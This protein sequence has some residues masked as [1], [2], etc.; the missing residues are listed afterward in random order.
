M[1]SKE[2][3]RLRAEDREVL[4]AR[5]RSRN[6]RADDARRAR[7]ILMLSDGATYDDV[8][9]AVGCGR[10]YIA[11]W[12][13]R[14]LEQGVAGMYARH[15]GR[16]A[17]AM[18]PR[19]EA[20]ILAR[21]QRKPKD[22]STH[23]S[24]RKLADEVGVSHMLVQRVWARA[25]I[26]PHRIKR[27]MA[28]NDPDFESKAADV[29]GLYLNPPQHAAV[30]SLDEKTQVQALDRLVPVLPLSPGRLER[31]GFEY[32]RHGTLSLY[33]ALNTRTGRVLGAPVEKH[34][35]AALVAFLESLLASVPRRQEVHVIL[36]N[37]SAH[38]SRLVQRFLVDHP[39]LHF[40]FTPTYSSWLN[41]I[42]IW[43]SKIERD[44]IARG[45]FTS[46]K[47]LARKLMRYIKRYNQHPK[48][49]KWKYSDPARRIRI[50]GSASA[51]TGN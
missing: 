44:V 46:V 10:A 25:G 28:S 13:G 22:G 49:I 21:T 40:H 11:R 20:R 33:A 8:Q 32:Y 12:R 26:K 1:R 36:D 45:V 29:I 51:V 6:G 17:T 37:L 4:E 14:F 2:P 3:I 19:M 23:W 50:H 39:R 18:T 34:N 27:Y 16:K 38:K 7:V 31:H 43:F 24:T 9:E 35:S 41:Q 48:P 15:K 47:D 42:E 5:T 30:F